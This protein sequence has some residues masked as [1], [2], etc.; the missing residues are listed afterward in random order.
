MFY[1]F[2]IVFDH[3]FCF[4]VCCVCGVSLLCWLLMIDCFV[5]SSAVVVMV[6][7][8]VVTLLCLFG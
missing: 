3:L 7:N 8:V 1:S 6:V 5:S 4:G 2:W